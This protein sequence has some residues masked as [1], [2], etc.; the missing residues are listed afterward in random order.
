[1]ITLEQ[2]S[3]DLLS[4]ESKNILETSHE[5][6]INHPTKQRAITWPG[7]GPG[8]LVQRG[9]LSPKLMALSAARAAAPR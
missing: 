5:G 4:S 7:A 2:V 6:V 8:S 1:M 9:E 3:A